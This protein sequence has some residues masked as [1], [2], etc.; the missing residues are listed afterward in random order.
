[1]QSAAI[2]KSGRL[3]RRGYSLVEVA[4]VMGIVAVITAAFFTVFG[5]TSIQQQVD[6]T[7][8]EV[9]AIET[10]THSLFA[11]AGS[12]SAITT[13]YIATNGNLPRADSNGT[14][15]VSPFHT[16]VVIAPYT[17]ATNGDAFS[18]AMSNIAPKACHLL[19]ITNWGHYFMGMSI[20]GQFT[21]RDLTPVQAQTEC[22]ASVQFNLYFD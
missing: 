13:A 21:N 22:G 11:T 20:D 14:A 8:I 17:I 3:T 5:A 1:M 2:T 9:N 12:Y 6:N 7:I 10:A 18:I 4:M 19:S 15:I 16:K